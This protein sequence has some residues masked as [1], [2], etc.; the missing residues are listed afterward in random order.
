MSRI[1]V[2]MIRV[3]YSRTPS[4]YYNIGTYVREICIERREF[5]GRSSGANL[6]TRRAHVIIEFSGGKCPAV[7]LKTE[8]ARANKNNK[9]DVA[10]TRAGADENNKKPLSDRPL[11]RHSAAAPPIIR[12][13][14]TYLHVL[15]LLLLLY[16]YNN[17]KLL[18]AAAYCVATRFSL[19]E[20]RRRRASVPRANGPV[21][22]SLYCAETELP[23]GPDA[24]R[25]R[26]RVHS[27]RPTRRRRRR[28]HSRH[29]H[30]VRMLP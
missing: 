26:G 16:E 14:D 1:A 9:R 30:R 4:L 11:V 27:T 24:E 10:R 21:L 7:S 6:N 28:L 18:V 20:C 17:V 19:D 23:S 22:C 29:R 3:H 15:L 13:R 12:P 5:D 8:W 25:R 2:P